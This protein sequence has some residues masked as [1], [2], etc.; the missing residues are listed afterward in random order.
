MLNAREIHKL[1]SGVIDRATVPQRRCA[2][3]IIVLGMKRR[4]PRREI[5]LHKIELRGGGIGGTGIKIRTAILKIHG[6]ECG[7]ET[8]GDIGKIDVPRDGLAQ[9]IEI[10][11]VAVSTSGTGGET[12]RSTHAIIQSHAG[13]GDAD[14]LGIIALDA[15]KTI[16][17]GIAVNV[18]GVIETG[19]L[20]SESRDYLF[21]KRLVIDCVGIEE[22]IGGDG[23]KRPRAPGSIHALEFKLFQERK[24]GAERKIGVVRNGITIVFSENPDALFSN[25]IAHQMT[26]KIYNRGIAKSLGNCDGTSDGDEILGN[27]RRLLLNIKDELLPGLG[28]FLRLRFTIRHSFYVMAIEKGFSSK[29]TSMDASHQTKIL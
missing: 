18:D 26:S 23:Q 9:K 14:S 10:R 20:Q 1:V 8:T 16:D 15:E 19:R 7:I 6:V 21:I 11:P 24:P 3:T 28:Y 4:V 13:S 12:E 29:E 22:K 2:A 5:G 27:G 25:L 17:S